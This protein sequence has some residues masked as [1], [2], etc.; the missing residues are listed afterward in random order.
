MNGKAQFTVRSTVQAFLRLVFFVLLYQGAL[1]KDG[2]LSVLL[3]A[4]AAMM[5]VFALM[6]GR[7]VLG[8]MLR[9]DENKQKLSYNQAIKMGL[10]RLGRG[11]LYGIPVM[12]LLGWVLNRY[13]AVNGQEF[14]RMIKRFSWFL[15]R[16]PENTTPD[17]GL[18]GFFV[19]VMLL[20]LYFMLGWRQDMAMEYTVYTGDLRGKTLAAR[21]VREKGEGKLWCVSLVH[22]LLFAAAF[23]AVAAVIM[24][25]VWQQLK[26]T[27]GMMALMQTVFAMLDTPLPWNTLVALLL[28]YMLVCH[29]LCMLRKI[30][31]ARAVQQIER[32]L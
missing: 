11:L 27:E 31:L 18:M 16:A 21:Q 8:Q 29:P 6:P 17:V 20:G 10:V 32:R 4:C 2:V 22:F 23:A 13:H 1:V 12:F 26:T 19:P 30:R 3:F 15:F 14:G 25:S 9:Q 7:F 5:L 24:L 28:V